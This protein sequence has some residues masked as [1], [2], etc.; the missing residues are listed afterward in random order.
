MAKTPEADSYRPLVKLKDVEDFRDPGDEAVLGDRRD[1]KLYRY[2]P[3]IK[4]AVNVALATGRPLLVWGRTG[5]G[6]SLLAFNLAR[7]M[8]RRYYEFVVTS[9]SQARDLF[10]RFD[11][12]RRLGDAQSKERGSAAPERR[13]ARGALIWQSQYPYVE[14]GPLWWSID[15]EGARRRGYPGTE[16]PPFQKAADPVVWEP[17]ALAGESSLLLI[18]EIDKAELDFPNNLLVPLGSW[19]FT[20][21]EVAR[22][23]TMAPGDAQDPAKRPL[24]V[25]TS[26]RERE[27]PETFLRR[28][29]VLEI[30]PPTVAA[31][32]ELAATVFRRRDPKLFGGIAEQL[33]ELRG[34]ENLSTA[35]FLDA[36]QAIQKLQAA[37]PAL[38]EIV[39]RS[40][41]RA[42]EQ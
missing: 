35:E 17:G 7:V 14:P 27:L 9:R 5:C 23:V 34:A 1:G 11:A 42:T 2:T 29:I 20:V 21:E 4:L 3:E 36:V 28:C 15:P 33:V 19:Q 22:P 10:Y 31:L 16:K 30:P 13:V 37:E 41:W 40:A 26:N 38:S 32:V 24:V 8:R 39:R 12:V 25:I 6:K 18:D